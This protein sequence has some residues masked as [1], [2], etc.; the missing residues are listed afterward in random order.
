MAL[1]DETVTDFVRDVLLG[2]T[3]ETTA[4]DRGHDPVR[5]VSGPAE[6]SISSRSLTM[7]NARR[8]A[9]RELQPSW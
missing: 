3:D 1:G 9:R 4:G 8:V 2:A 7:R 6:R 5:G